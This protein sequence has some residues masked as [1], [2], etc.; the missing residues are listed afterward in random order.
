M[1]IDNKLIIEGLLKDHPEGLTIQYIAD[2]TE[3]A[4]NTVSIILAALKGEGKIEI[5]EKGP[6]KLH[7][8]NWNKKE[9]KE[10]E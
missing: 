10:D 7:I 6:S 9:I 5:K 1:N 2:K 8:W 3:L 4:R